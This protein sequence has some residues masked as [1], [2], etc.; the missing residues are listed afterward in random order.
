VFQN[1]VLR[2]IFRTKR[3]EMTGECRKLHNEELYHLYSS[4]NSLGDKI[5]KNKM[6]GA[7]SAYGGQERRI[8]GFGGET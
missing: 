2:K 4:P 6:G 5:E 1:R 7:C 8:E 3:Y